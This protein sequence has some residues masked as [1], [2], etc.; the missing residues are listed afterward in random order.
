MC[1]LDGGRESLD[2]LKRKG[3]SL[4][5]FSRWGFQM[6]IFGLSC[7]DGPDRGKPQRREHRSTVCVRGEKSDRKGRG[8][9]EPVSSEHLPMQN[10]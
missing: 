6:P 1:V 2:L 5:I 7:G 10:E 8:G 3:D 4:K 9:E